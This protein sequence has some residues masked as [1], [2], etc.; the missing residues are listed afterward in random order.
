MPFHRG[1]F[2]RSIPRTRGERPCPRRTV[3]IPQTP[4]REPVVDKH[5]RRNPT[6]AENQRRK[7]L[8]KKNFSK[9]QKRKTLSEKNCS[10][11]ANSWG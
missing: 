5:R 1:S 2:S 6:R 11:T 10:N 3:A 4:E 9:N 7:T 8:S